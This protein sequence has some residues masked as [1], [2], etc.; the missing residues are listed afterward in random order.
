MNPPKT[1]SALRQEGEGLLLK[2]VGV[3]D[4]TQSQI[5]TKGG[6]QTSSNCKRPKLT[7]FRGVVADAEIPSVT[8]YYP[9]FIA[10]PLNP[11]ILTVSGSNLSFDSCCLMSHNFTFDDKVRY[12]V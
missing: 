3:N 1:K 9:H 7:F 6:V 2:Q 5:K 11:L 8:L 4:E 10:T 12:S